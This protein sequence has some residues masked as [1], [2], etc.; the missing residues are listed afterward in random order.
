MDRS[1]LAGT[2]RAIAGKGYVEADYRPA[3]NA[4]ATTANHIARTVQAQPLIALVIA[5]MVGYLVGTLRR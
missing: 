4:V 3:A 1:G 2:A 5:G